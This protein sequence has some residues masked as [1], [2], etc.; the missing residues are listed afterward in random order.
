[1]KPQGA[2]R[3]EEFAAEFRHCLCGYVMAQAREPAAHDDVDADAVAPL[4]RQP[5]AAVTGR[6]NDIPET[7]ERK[8]KSALQPD[9]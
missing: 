4:L 6:R 2:T 5:E 3:F 1:M 9:G 8:L 7:A